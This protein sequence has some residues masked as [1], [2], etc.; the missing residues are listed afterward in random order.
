MVENKEE[1]GAGGHAISKPGP[2]SAACS[3]AH[4]SGVLQQHL[5]LPLGIK[6]NIFLGPVVVSSVD[7]RMAGRRVWCWQECERLARGP[8]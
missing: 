6:V 7:G 5:T 8:R 4:R 3:A 2:V 1:A